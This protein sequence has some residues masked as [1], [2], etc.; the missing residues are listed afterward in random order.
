MAALMHEQLRLNAV[1]FQ[2][3]VDANAVLGNDV[4]VV[5][6]V[7]HQYGRFDATDPMQI[8]ARLPEI[9]VVAGRTILIGHHQFVAHMAIAVGLSLFVSRRCG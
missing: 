7:R 3:L 8:I 9:V 6:R 2:S 5:K 1:F 4:P